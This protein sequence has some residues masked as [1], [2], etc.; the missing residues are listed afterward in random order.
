MFS[1]NAEKSVLQIDDK[2]KWNYYLIRSA[3]GLT[4][5]NSVLF[6]LGSEEPLFHFK[7]LIWAVLGMI[8]LILLLYSLI[9]KSTA[10][11]IPLSEIKAFRQKALLGRKR[12]SLLLKNG[13]KRD[14]YF[15]TSAEMA[16]M[17]NLLAAQDIP[18]K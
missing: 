5:I 12:C 4:V 9:K 11:E 18:V 7:N 15:Q 10:A 1:F 16:S 17:K 3:V 13:K 14:L 2:L 8:S 6:P